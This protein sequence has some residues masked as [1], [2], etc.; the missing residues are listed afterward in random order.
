MICLLLILFVLVMV[1]CL[2]TVGPRWSEIAK[3]MTGRTDNAVK[4]RWYSTVRRVERHRRAME[5]KANGGTTTKPRKSKRQDISTLKSEV[6][7][8]F[9]IMD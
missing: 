5:T 9:L 6:S 2:K 1:E 3:R 7:M 8:P 4:N